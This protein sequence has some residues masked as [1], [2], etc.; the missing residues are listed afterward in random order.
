VGSWELARI[1]LKICASEHVLLPWNKT[2][3]KEVNNM[4][5]AFG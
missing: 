2:I 1:V 3:K 4:Y 5:L